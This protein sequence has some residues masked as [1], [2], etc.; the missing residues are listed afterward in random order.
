[1][2]CV[3]RDA[4]WI[5]IIENSWNFSAKVSGEFDHTEYDFA[6]FKYK[7]YVCM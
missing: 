4:K 5:F 1:M 2:L 3:T 7:A 6:V